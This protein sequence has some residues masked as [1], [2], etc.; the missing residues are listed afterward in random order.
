MVFQPN[1]NPKR[2]RSSKIKPVL[3][4]L[5]E[6]LVSLGGKP[7]PSLDEPLHLQECF[8][9]KSR[10][11]SAALFAVDHLRSSLLSKWEHLRLGIDSK[12]V[13][14]SA[15]EAS[16]RRCRRTNELWEDG[17]P[18]LSSFQMLSHMR[19][20]I[21]RVLG[22]TPPPISELPLFLGRG[23]TYKVGMA[24]PRG[25]KLDPKSGND[26]TLQLLRHSD[27]MASLPHIEAVNLVPGSRLTTVPKSYKTDRVICVEPTINGMVQRGYGKLIRRKLFDVFGLDIRTQQGVNRGMIS[28]SGGCEKYA[29]IDFA[30]ASDT[31]SFNVV[32]HLLPWDWFEALAAAACPRYEINGEWR[33]FEK[34]SSMGCGFTFELETLIFSAMCVASGSTPGEWS[35]FGDDVIVRREL[36]GVVQHLGEDLGFEVN[37][38]KTYASGPFRESCGFDSFNGICVTPFRIRSRKMDAEDDLFWIHNELVRWAERLYGVVPHGPVVEA[39]MRI[40]KLSRRVLLGPDGYGDSWFIANFSEAKPSVRRDKRQFEGF[41]VKGLFRK[42]SSPRPCD[43]TLAY[44]LHEASRSDRFPRTSLPSL[45]S[46]EDLTQVSAVGQSF[47][48]KAIWSLCR[49][50]PEVLV[51][52]SC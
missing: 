34:F 39:C 28:T 32:R 48:V 18:R 42:Y 11:E 50:W 51:L 27:V 16:E 36:A 43:E 33:E 20:I 37:V 21:Y 7:L 17:I 19:D 25:Q 41:L 6:M 14:L 38:D 24:K 2:V 40:R 44:A 29:T 35:V 22:S 23:A 46:V 3:S 8:L 1:R 5:S 45:G 30:A 52:G 9:E 31:I 47:T 13:A 10:H 15:F 49:D 4:V 12:A 26:A